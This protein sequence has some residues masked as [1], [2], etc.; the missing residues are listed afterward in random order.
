[1]KQALYRKYRPQ[2]FTEVCGQDHITKILC[3][4]IES[5][6]PSHAYLFTG[7]RG[8]GKTSSAKILSKAV[9]CEHPENGNPCGKCPN[10]VS[11][12]DGLNIDV[13][14]MDAASN[15]R[16]DDMRELIGNV[17]Y[18]PSTCKYKVYIID[19]VH[20]LSPSAFNALLK[21]IEEPPAHVIFILATTEVQAVPATILSRC[22]RFDFN[23]APAD[24]IADRLKYVCECENMQI[25]DDAA[26]LIAKLSD[27]GFRDALSMLDVCGSKGEKITVE[28]VANAVGLTG[29]DSLFKL[30]EAIR[31][32]DIAS[33]LRLIADLYE[34]SC[35]MMRLCT[36]LTEYYRNIMVAKAVDNPSNLINESPNEIE[37][38]CEVAKVTKFEHATK[39]TELLGECM[40]LMKQGKNQRVIMETTLM[41]M[42]IADSTPKVEQIANSS[43]SN[44]EV[45][46]L[47]L[48]IDELESALKDIKSNKTVV[49]NRTAQTVEKPKQPKKSKQPVIR[50]K[51]DFDKAVELDCWPEALEKINAKSQMLANVLGD[52][53]AFVSGDFLLLDIPSPDFSGLV[54]QNARH[55]ETV[56][57]AVQELTGKK[58][59][60]APWSR[61]RQ[62]ENP[63]KLDKF[64]SENPD[65][66]T[67]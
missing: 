4:Q 13:I 57:E 28:I 47:K 63:E 54:N 29:R 6:T 48:R 38:I 10:C 12:T 21:T 61:E 65:T 14:E 56:R 52:S 30:D 49:D 27:G 2:T 20:M 53:K 11:I 32:N 1:M 26:I 46:S 55:K 45:E 24:V 39:A 41:K 5:G 8:T 36:D 58:Y 18:P 34:H 23:R 25:E 9:N 42:C 37:R 50:E 19:E 67:Q 44:E 15:S 17:M 22:Q 64:V 35:D 66:V 51:I 62:V 59:K 7:S 3:S 43:V 33:L 16:V 31:N 60:L 40:K